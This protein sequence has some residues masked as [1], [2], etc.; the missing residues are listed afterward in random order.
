MEEITI[1]KTKEKISDLESQLELLSDY[2]SAVPGN[3]IKEGNDLFLVTKDPKLKFKKITESNGKYH[4]N[5]PKSR[6]IK[7]LERKY[8]ELNLKINAVYLGG[9]LITDE[10]EIKKITQRKNQIKEIQSKIRELQKIIKEKETEVENEKRKFLKK[11]S[12]KCLSCGK[13]VKS[14]QHVLPEKNLVLCSKCWQKPQYIK[15]FKESVEISEIP[16]IFNLSFEQIRSFEK[17]YKLKNNQEKIPTENIEKVVKESIK[18]GENLLYTKELYEN[19]LKPLGVKKS[20]MYELEEEEI[21][22]PVG[23]IKIQ[24]KKNKWTDAKI[25]DKRRINTPKVVTFVARKKQQLEENKIKKSETLKQIQR[26]VK[27]K[28]ENIKEQLEILKTY[29]LFLETAFYLY[30]ANHYAKTPKYKKYSALLYDLKEKVLLKAYQKHPEIFKILFI[31]RGDRIYYCEKCKENAYLKWKNEG[32][33]ETGYSFGEWLKEFE[34]PCEDCIVEEDYYS[35]IEF[36]I[37]TPVA[38]FNFHIPYP[39][40]EEMF[41]K[42]KLQK[43][44]MDKEEAFIKFGRELEKYESLI[45]PLKTVVKKLEEYLNND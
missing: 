27:E 43:I 34:K 21:I 41:D 12:S 19:I 30:H 39:K 26:K 4:L 33:Y 8:K 31:E 23:T 38:K 15:H 16:R 20:W 6:E 29:H 18:E 24:I 28:R 25:W 40:V 35:L 10:K 1:E 17:A 11:K 13:I 32:G 14:T 7:K 42:N 5:L 9:K 3:L 22:K 2:I 36:K 45:V 44:K 37:D